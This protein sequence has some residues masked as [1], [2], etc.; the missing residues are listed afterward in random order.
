MA[1]DCSADA[2][3][4][5]RTFAARHALTIEKVDE[6]NVELLMRVPRQNGLSFEL[7]LCCQNGDELNIG[8]AEFWST[9]FP[10]EKVKERVEAA[11]D[12]LVS[13][14]CTVLTIW[15]SGRYVGGK[16]QRK[17]DAG[18]KT[19]ATHV[20]GLSVPFLRTVQQRIANERG[21][22]T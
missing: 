4:L 12:G 10:F 17:A 14:E 15:R 6:P 20:Q 2:E 21:P 7:K 11:L 13:G 8:V 18:W 5:F 19:I 3:R 9:F 22:P 1:R 16:L